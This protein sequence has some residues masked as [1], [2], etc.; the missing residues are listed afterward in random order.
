MICFN[1]E[2]ESILVLWTYLGCGF[3]LRKKYPAAFCPWSHHINLGL[4]N[5]IKCLIICTQFHGQINIFAFRSAVSW[6]HYMHNPRAK[7][8]SDQHQGFK[9]REKNSVCW[10]LRKANKYHLTR[11][12]VC[13]REYCWVVTGWFPE[14]AA[15]MS[16]SVW[17]NAAPLH[18]Q[19]HF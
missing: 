10:W 8:M 13:C 6:R 2:D 17:F 5:W 3:L 15:L 18:P 12:A 14:A 7:H 19:T 11:H 1:H 4:H 9:N 16:P